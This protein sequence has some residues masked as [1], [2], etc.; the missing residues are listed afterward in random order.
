MLEVSC[1][2]GIKWWSCP[3][4]SLVCDPTM[5][6]PLCE[7]AGGPPLLS[8]SASGRAW[9]IRVL[10]SQAPQKQLWGLPR[11]ALRS[12]HGPTGLSSAGR[13]PVGHLA[14][15]VTP[16]PQLTL[17]RDV[18]KCRIGKAEYPEGRAHGFILGRHTDV[19][20]LELCLSARPSVWAGQKN[21]PHWGGVL[22]KDKKGT[23]HSLPCLKP[24]PK[25][26]N[27]TDGSFVQRSRGAGET[28]LP[29]PRW[30]PQQ[31]GGQEDGPG[32]PGPCSK[33][34]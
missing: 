28:A 22:E 19:P 9:G 25:P 26:Q 12:S 29:P 27:H 33:L 32:P 11:G 24:F 18:E 1:A 7:G 20:G 5:R 14:P 31:L 23:G 34:P 8:T 4:P 17:P 21:G 3:P 16:Y 6:E 2:L 30:V 15:R 13:G 10:L